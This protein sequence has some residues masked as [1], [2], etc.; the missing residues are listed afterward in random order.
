M[1]IFAFRRT[2]CMALALLAALILIPATAMAAEPDLPLLPLTELTA[3]DVVLDETEFTVNGKEI[4]PN[5]TV[6]S[7]GTLLTLDKDYTLQYED[8]IEEGAARVIVTGTQITGYTGT[9]EVP[10]HIH[11]EE[12]EFSVSEITSSNV[13]LDGT[14]FLYTGTPIAPGITVTVDGKLLT[15]GQD[16]TLEYRD[17]IQPGTATAIVRGISNDRGGY[18][19]EVKVSFAI[20]NPHAPSLITELEKSHIIL[21]ADRFVYTGVPITP[22]ITVTVSGKVLTPGQDYTLEYRDNIQPGTGTVTVRGISDAQG[23]YSG[24][25]TMDFIID[26]A[27]QQTQQPDYR[28]LKGGDS[29]WRQHSG[30]PLSFTTNAKNSD[31][32]GVSVDGKPLDAAHYTITD[33]STAIHVK[34]SFLRNLSLGTHTISIHYLDGDVQGTFRIVEGQQT[35]NPYT[36]DGSAHLWAGVMF[37]SLTAAAA[38]IFARYKH[39]L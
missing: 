1:N 35:S 16:Y 15:A 28:L 31:F 33:S 30:K 6:R 7:G 14:E 25:V 21:D 20:T 22:S 38:L 10:F 29:A 27:P 2:L 18:S 9:V 36:G 37:V 5:V 26:N 17:N 4:R 34:D 39:L 32:T 23:G 13:A 8:N 11:P 12:M 3:A 24:E 19:G